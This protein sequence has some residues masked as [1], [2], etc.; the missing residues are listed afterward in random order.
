M[1][2]PAELELRSLRH[3][4]CEAAAGREVQGGDRAFL[5]V[6]RPAT[7]RFSRSRVQIP[8]NAACRHRPLPSGERTR[9]AHAGTLAYNSDLARE[10]NLHRSEPRSA[11]T[12]ISR[13]NLL[14]AAPEVPV[15][16][17][18]VLALEDGT[19]FRGRFDRRARHDHRR[20]GVQHRDDRLPGNPDR[21]R[22]TPGRSS[23]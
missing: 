22:R 11:S 10:T 20:S 2:A 6:S 8:A 5:R 19:V 1:H 13:A 16:I 17:P 7:C 12:V 21:S 4:P 9:V 18:A 14:I 15:T 23:R 3:A